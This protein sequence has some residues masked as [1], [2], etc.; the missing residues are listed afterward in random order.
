MKI[1]MITAAFSIVVCGCSDGD[2]AYKLNPNRDRLVFGSFA[3]YCVGERCVEIYA[4]QD[5]KLYEDKNDNYPQSGSPVDFNFELLSDD[6]FELAEDMFES[7]PAELLATES[8]TFGCPDCTDGGGVYI[9]IKRDTRTEIFF[10]DN[11]KNNIPEYLHPL[12]DNVR[13]KIDV[14]Q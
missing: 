14:L 8:T 11:F 10:I 12:V 4:L 7:I 13:A 3:G 1:Q 9:E 2:G 5:G 6:K